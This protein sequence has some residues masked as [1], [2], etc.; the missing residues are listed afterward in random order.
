MGT[1]RPHDQGSA[2][3]TRDQKRE[4]VR[5]GSTIS[6]QT[7]Q[8]DLPACACTVQPIIGGGNVLRS[9]ISGLTEPCKLYIL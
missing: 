8:N 7:I 1:S 5:S 6:G 9:V 4:A 3:E 2:L